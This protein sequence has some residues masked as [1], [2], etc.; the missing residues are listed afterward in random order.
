M[1]Q[2]P[3]GM[4][5]RRILGVLASGVPFYAICGS[6]EDD[7]DKEKNGSGD[8]T[9]SGDSEGGDTGDS[10][11]QVEGGATTGTVSLEE[12]EKIKARM[13]AA[14]RQRVEAQNR[15]R[16]IDD[17]DKSE[18]EKAQRDLKEYQL[19]VKELGE[20]LTKSRIHN[21]FL[22]SNKY[23]W[24][25]PETALHLL[26]MAEVKVED[27][28]KVSGLENA[29]EALAKSKPFLL[30]VEE[31]NGKKNQKQNGGR[32]SG[33]Q[34]PANGSNT[35]RASQRSELEKKYPALRR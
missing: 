12:Y 23:S 29:I 34:P 18:L 8:D 19:Q 15:L 25:D 33:N 9:G 21:K 17:K 13:A 1:G 31:G 6:E 11:T 10:G 28:G 24:H 35:D 30:K 27:D 14:D 26:D 16:E 20:A 4:R 3:V 2:S 22:A 5:Q 32:P 7:D